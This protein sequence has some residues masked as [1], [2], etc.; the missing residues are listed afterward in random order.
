MPTYEYM[1]RYYTE[2]GKLII[3][4]VMWNDPDAIEYFRFDWKG[5]HLKSSSA[6]AQNGN[7]NRRQAEQNSGTERNRNGTGT[8]RNNILGQDAGAILSKTNKINNEQNPA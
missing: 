8:E 2:G 1:Q 7:G 4:E 5:R 3:E 6:R